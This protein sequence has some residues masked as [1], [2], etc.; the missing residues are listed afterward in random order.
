MK[1]IDMIN[2]NLKDQGKITV[3]ESVSNAMATVNQLFSR[4]FMLVF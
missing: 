3:V 2:K 4:L 1:E